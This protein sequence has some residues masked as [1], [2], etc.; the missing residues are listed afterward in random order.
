[1][2]NESSSP[3]KQDGALWDYETSRSNEMKGSAQIDAAG[4]SGTIRSSSAASSV[5]SSSVDMSRSD[6][7]GVVL[8]AGSYSNDDIRSFSSEASATGD[9][10]DGEDDDENSLL[11]LSQDS[12]NQSTDDDSASSNSNADIRLK[13]SISQASSRS[14]SVQGTVEGSTD[15]DKMYSNGRVN[16]LNN[17]MAIRRFGSGSIVPGFFTW[18][19]GEEGLEICSTRTDT[20]DD[21]A[22]GFMKDA[23]QPPVKMTSTQKPEVDIR[24]SAPEE[25]KEE[26][27]P[28]LTLHKLIEEHDWLATKRLLLKEDSNNSKPANTRSIETVDDF[29]RTPLAVACMQ[30]DVPHALLQLL[31]AFYPKATSLPDLN[32][33]VPLHLWC[34]HSIQGLQET[35]SNAAS[36]AEILS[37]S[38]VNPTWSF[39]SLRSNQ[40]ELKAKKQVMKTLKL[41]LQFCKEAILTAN[42]NGNIPLH[43]A[44]ECGV[45]DKEMLRLL[46]QANPRSV[47][48]INDNGSYPLHFVGKSAIDTDA[49]KLLIE[50]NRGAVYAQDET[51]C[52]P[53]ACAVRAKV[54][55]KVVKVFLDAFAG[56]ATQVDDRN[57]TPIDTAWRMLFIQAQ[58]SH[59]KNLDLQL[60]PLHLMKKPL[61]TLWRTVDMLLKAGYQDACKKSGIKI[62]WRVMHAA[63]E[64][65][66]QVELI[67]MLLMMNEKQIRLRDEK[68]NLPL[69]IAAASE[70]NT[71]SM[72]AENVRKSIDVLLVA[73]PKAASIVDRRKRLP[74][75]TAIESGKTWHSGIKSIH[76]A[77]NRASR[78]QDPKS[79]FFV[80]FSNYISGN[81]VISGFYY[82]IPAYC[83]R[84]FGVLLPTYF[85]SPSCL[86]R[87]KKDPMLI[88]F[89]QWQ[90]KRHVPVMMK[91]IGKISVTLIKIMK[92]KE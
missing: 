22:F 21:D 26:D 23:L 35:D 44:I 36:D 72:F 83:S 5:S 27:I 9:D 18:T 92:S 30:R 70:K 89:A 56:A 57:V 51:G 3:K 67:Q 14:F 28:N 61:K 38:G 37:L 88:C 81:I 11:E 20:R 76:Q 87:C 65:T 53:L 86:L 48:S 40:S 66:S 46:I 78:M 8:I 63:A 62:K 16:A 49:V 4:E 54:N 31:L 79:N 75:F 24:E 42:V 50:A 69:H 68:G 58:K 17:D 15:E 74:I 73:Y 6:R 7:G 10:D 85:F 80:S 91:K 47:F 64:C 55:A 34:R 60:L 25:E 84:I 19:C 77:E 12:R 32:G 13:I 82:F 43:I 2:G 59:G 71:T 90:K 52:T 29:G 45:T 1:M 33:D 39:G 41:L